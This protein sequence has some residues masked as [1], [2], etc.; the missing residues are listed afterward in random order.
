MSEQIQSNHSEVDE[1]ELEHIQK[2]IKLYVGIFGALLVLTVLT[3]V[4]A[5]AFDFDQMVGWEG[6]TLNIIIGLLIAAAKATLVALFFMHL[7][8]EKRTIYRF[9]IF[10]VVFAVGLMVLFVWGFF[11]VPAL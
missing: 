10:A 6:H 4:V 8:N 9:L 3:V 5:K 7:S 2:H 11:D 1:H